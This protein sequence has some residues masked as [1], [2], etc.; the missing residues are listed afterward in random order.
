M[1]TT[2]ALLDRTGEVSHRLMRFE[3]I[4]SRLAS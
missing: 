4:R 2:V 3:E 1:A